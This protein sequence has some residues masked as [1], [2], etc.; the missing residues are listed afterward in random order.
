MRARRAHLAVDFT[1]LVVF[2]PENPVKYELQK[3]PSGIFPS[4]SEPQGKLDESS[5]MSP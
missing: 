5:S 3:E 1:R 4:Y 2:P